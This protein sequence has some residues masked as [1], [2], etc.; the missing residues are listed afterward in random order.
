MR[1]TPWPEGCTKAPLLNECGL[2]Q[3]YSTIHE[4]PTTLLANQRE[5]SLVLLMDRP[6]QQILFQVPNT[7]LGWRYHFGCVLQD[8]TDIAST[9]LND[10]GIEIQST[11]RE[12]GTMLFTFGTHNHDPMRV[13]ILETQVDSTKTTTDC[14]IW[15]KWDEIPYTNMWAD[16]IF[17][18]PWFV[19]DER[20]EM[21]GHFLFDGPPGSDSPLVA[22]NCH[23]LDT[24]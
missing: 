14:G 3:S 19:T 20:V 2:S 24:Q 18:L 11:L 23:R 17:W 4:L 21:E 22:H 6:K 9:L 7:E 13:H 15:T 12:A 1:A 8:K 10:H 16:D 5:L